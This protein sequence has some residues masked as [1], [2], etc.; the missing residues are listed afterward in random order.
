MWFVLFFFA[1]V[2]ANFLLKWSLFQRFHL[3]FEEIDN[4]QKKFLPIVEQIKKQLHHNSNKALLLLVHLVKTKKTIQLQFFW[5]NQ[6]QKIH[7]T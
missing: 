2:V 4:C 6:P 1:I 5:G 7:P 3:T